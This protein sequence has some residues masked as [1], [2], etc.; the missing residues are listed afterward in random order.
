V[1]VTVGGGFLTADSG[2]SVVR[3]VP[4]ASLPASDGRVWPS[5][6]V[7][8]GLWAVNTSGRV[9]TGT[10]RSCCI[11]S[12][13]GRAGLTARRRAERPG[14]LVYA[15]RPRRALRGSYADAQ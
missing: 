15:P 3:K 2:N 12:V 11:A 13:H 4:A 9:N 8:P 7:S 10:I 1:A 14:R 6:T 5:G